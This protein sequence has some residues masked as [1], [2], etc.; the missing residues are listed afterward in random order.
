MIN[1]YAAIKTNFTAGQVS[2]DLLGR[3]DLKIYENG[4]RRLEN[5]IIHPTGGVSRRRGL[6]YV[7]R[8]DKPARLIPFEFN[9]EQIYLLCLTD[10]QMQVY[11]QDECIA[12][13]ETPWKEEQLFQLNYTQSA[14]TLLV[15]HPDV[16]P[17][18]I[19]RNN[20]E[21]WKISD[22]EYYSK[23]NMIYMPYYNFYQRKPQIWAS[24]TGGNITMAATEDVWM[25][26]HVGS[27]LKYQNGL[28][29]ITEVLTPRDIKGTVVKGL[30]GTGKTTDWSEA[31]FSSARGW[32]ASVTFHQN[33]M[34]I[35]GSRDL[36]NRLWMSKSSDLFNFDLGKA[37]DDEAIEFGILSDQVNAI[38]G[39]VSSRHLLVFTAG[40]E[41]MVTGD[42][43]TPE[44]VQLKRQTSVGIYAEK[45]LMPQQIDGATIFVSANGRQ[46]REFLYTDVEQAYQARDLTI[47]SGDI[48]RQ[49]RDIS[50]DRNECVVYLVLEDGTVSC[51][52]TYR[53][54]GVT[55]WSKLKTAGSFLSVAVIG[56]DIYFCV[57]RNNGYFI[58]KF[59]D[60]YYAD[61]AVCLTA[62]T[63]QCD[64]KGLEHLE[65]QE[66]AVL[67]NGFSL[68]K[69][70][71]RDGGISLLD[72]ADK[73]IV[74][75][76]YEHLIEPLP[77]MVESD[78]PYAPKALRVINARFRIINS[79]SFCIDIGSGYFPYPLKRIH[80]DAV[81]DSPPLT[82]SGDVQ[83]RALGWIRDMNRPIWSIKSDEPLAFTLLSAIAEIKLKG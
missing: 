42:P 10:G 45:S 22:W 56:N 8:T 54:E 16:P 75:L 41:W 27:Y 28:V 37:L 81:F 6:K 34:I 4:A 25:S 78:R 48:I 65:G 55:A 19:T 24:G 40:A 23:D 11:K 35:G 71:V 60:D 61:C 20:N 51:L 39:V 29:Q 50:F 12:V 70:T 73:I 31:A 62:D 21:V 18:Q 63:P 83:I 77:Y 3:G 59:E 2:S 5:V 69:F 53:T 74:G 43:L 82:Y 13:L 68:G 17:R 38:K 67:A 32:P 57:K 49:P 15:V 44:K 9:T 72:E 46:L 1:N 76:P 64:W 52:T 58:E 33:R 79:K 26:T 66:V 14:D 30:S 7:C 47:L 36:P 80:R